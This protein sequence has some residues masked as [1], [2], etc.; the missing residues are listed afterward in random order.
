MSSQKKTYYHYTD[1]SGVKGISKSKEIKASTD[2]TNDAVYGPGVYL[3]SMD[4]RNDPKEIIR[5]NYDDG[6]SV[7]NNP[8]MAAKVEN[9]VAVKLDSNE[10]QKVSNDRDVY[11]YKGDLDLNKHE[12][13][14]QKTP[15]TK[16]RFAYT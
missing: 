8:K 6:P 11:L 10:V 13:K 7:V 4:P 9:V 1:Q 3:T 14:I 2:T 12:H 15:N 16:N 5:N